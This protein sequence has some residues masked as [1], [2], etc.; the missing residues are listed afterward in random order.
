MIGSQ[1]DPYLAKYKQMLQDR[2][3]G[4]STEGPDA[5]EKTDPAIL[6]GKYVACC[7]YRVYTNF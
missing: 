6:D 1:P 4:S 7:I 3:H 5:T 2:L